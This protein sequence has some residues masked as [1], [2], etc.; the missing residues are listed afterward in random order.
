MN[1]RHFIVFFSDE[2]GGSRESHSVFYSYVVKAKSK[3]EAIDKYV[4]GP[5]N[6]WSTKDV[7]DF[8]AIEIN[9]KNYIG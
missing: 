1:E 9:D 7:N 2:D 4:N 6:T 8:D 5:K 3:K